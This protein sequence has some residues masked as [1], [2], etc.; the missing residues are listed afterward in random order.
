[1]EPVFGEVRRPVTREVVDPATGA[2]RRVV[3][4]VQ[5]EPAQIGVKRRRCFVGY[6][7]EEIPI[8]CRWE[9]VETGRERMKRLRGWRWS[10]DP[11]WPCEREAAARDAEPAPADPPPE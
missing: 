1:V 4:G 8:G 2:V 11:P 5:V 6:E 7:P 9:S 3:C 10:D